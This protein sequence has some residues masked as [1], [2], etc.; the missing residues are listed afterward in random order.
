[1]SVSAKPGILRSLGIVG[2]DHL[3]PV[4]LA[5][6]ATE[7]PLLLIGPHGSAKTLVLTRL[8]DALGLSHRHYNASLL[9]FDDLIGFPVPDEGKLVYLQTPA[10]IWD[11]ESVLFD[12]VSRCRSDL[13]NKLFPIVQERRVQGV[14]L[15]RLRHRWAAMNP[16]PELDGK[17]GGAPEYAGAEPLDI[18]L[19]DRFAFVVQV[20]DLKALSQA[21]QI[22]VLAGTSEPADVGQHH[23][24]SETVGRIR[25]RLPAIRE[26]LRNL[27]AEY[28][29]LVAVRLA[30]AGHPLSTRRAV[31]LAR[32]I[33]AV[34]AALEESGT[35][36]APEDP[37]FLALQHS[38]PDAAW[39]HPL[40]AAQALTIHRAV[41]AIAGARDASIKAIFTETDPARRIAL[42]LQ[43]SSLS[44]GERGQVLVDSY[45]SLDRVARLTLSAVL[46]PLLATRTDLP[47]AALETVA[48]DYATVAATG[49]R[50]VPVTGLVSGWKRAILGGW[51]GGL[52]LSN[53][54]NRVLKNVAATL[55]GGDDEFKPTQLERA[56]DHA[57]RCLAAPRRWRRV[58]KEAAPH[59][60]SRSEARA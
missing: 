12:E 45:A 44:V 42:A 7:S 22:A 33:D 25:G 53:V 35:A 21:D 36:Q 31:R 60:K 8:A 49:D 2:W 16:P 23:E 51:F 34:A 32:N 46:M 6:L 4:I 40:D 9:N 28:V 56:Y 57:V 29:Q 19:A 38:I 20:P 52:D 50:S 39:G 24:L 3:E 14:A 26:N 5:A 48:A 18:A 54:R 30:E 10:T 55:L 37:F 17:H 11:A 47:A 58:R 13:Q 41:W 15:E 1:V 27:V 59:T 43:T